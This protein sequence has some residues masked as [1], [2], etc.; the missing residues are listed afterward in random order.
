MSPLPTVESVCSL[1][2]QEESQ[3]EVLKTSSL[4]VEPIALYSR[5]DNAKWCSQCGH[6]AHTK[7]KCWHVIGY[8]SWHPKCKKFPQKKVD[9][10]QTHRGKGKGVYNGNMAANNVEASGKQ[11]GDATLT[12]LQI[13]QLQ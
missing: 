1:V 11:S 3:Q 12:P 7:E 13:E 10:S 4:E 9:R 8:P 2:Q 5:N 6:K